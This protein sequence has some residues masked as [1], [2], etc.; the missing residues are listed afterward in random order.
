MASARFSEPSELASPRMNGAELVKQIS[1][2]E[3]FGRLLTPLMV[4]MLL[5]VVIHDDEQVLLSKNN[6]VYFC[7][8]GS[9]NE[10]IKKSLDFLLYHTHAPGL[11]FWFPKKKSQSY[12]G[13]QK[14][15][16]SFSS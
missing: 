14:K 4:R 16:I 11:L 5:I 7:L 10:T 8:Y 12:F 15:S 2:S 9:R 6:E 3:R 13:V 1:P